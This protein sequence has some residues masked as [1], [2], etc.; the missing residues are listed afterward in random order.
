[1]SQ[2]QSYESEM[3]REATRAELDTE[4]LH[5]LGAA[6]IQ[7]PNIVPRDLELAVL[8][9]GKLSTEQRFGKHFKVNGEI[10]DTAGLALEVVKSRLAWRT[11]IDPGEEQ[12]VAHSPHYRRIHR[13]WI[14]QPNNKPLHTAFITVRLGLVAG[15][16]NSRQQPPQSDKGEARI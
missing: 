11:A 15:L 13:A 6:A 9:P 4:L 5:T 12:A 16:R 14:Y 7:L 1:M 8:F 2:Q 3:P 10:Q